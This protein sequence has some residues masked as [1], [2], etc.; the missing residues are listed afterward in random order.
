[1]GESRYRESV[2]ET[3]QEQG[4]SDH[5]YP[6]VLMRLTRNGSLPSKEQEDKDS[7]GGI[8]SRGNIYIEAILRTVN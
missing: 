3:F 4:F 7:S 8:E 1:M 2:F 6:K 5:S